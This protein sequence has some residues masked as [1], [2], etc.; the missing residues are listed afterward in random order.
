MPGFYETCTYIWGDDH[1]ELNIDNFE[2]GGWYIWENDLRY[3]GTSRYLVLPKPLAGG[4]YYLYIF[5]NLK[6][7]FSDA[8]DTAESKNIITDDISEMVQFVSFPHIT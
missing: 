7:F 5:S 1:F 8:M 4:S 6:F 2:E 3:F